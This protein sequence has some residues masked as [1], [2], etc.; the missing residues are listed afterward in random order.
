[1][2][3][4]TTTLPGHHTEFST[5]YL[6]IWRFLQHLHQYIRHEKSSANS[7]M[8][9][10]SR[11]DSIPGLVPVAHALVL[12][13]SAH[14]GKAW[15]LDQLGHRC[16]LSSS[17][18]TAYPSTSMTGGYPVTSDPAALCQ[19]R[20]VFTWLSPS[21]TLGFY[22]GPIAWLCFYY[23]DYYFFFFCGRFCPAILGVASCGLRLET[24]ELYVY[25]AAY[26]HS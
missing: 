16:L 1:M 20:A 12:S 2:H 18:G 9:S 13:L 11:S 4:R 6:L 26:A 14:A 8:W 7:R 5:I 25:P 17:A 15:T 24:S 3:H 23:Y 22:C 10:N 19:A 21:P